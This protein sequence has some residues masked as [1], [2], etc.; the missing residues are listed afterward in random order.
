[1]DAAAVNLLTFFS[2]NEKFIIP[3][4]QR[5]YSWEARQCKELFEDIFKLQ[6]N[7]E[8]LLGMVIYQT[9]LQANGLH[10]N[11]II[12]GQQRTT[13]ISLLLKAIQTRL[14]EINQN[15]QFDH[16]ISQIQAF[17]YNY[18]NGQ[19]IKLELGNM[20]NAD[21]QSIIN[22]PNNIV[23]EHQ[24]PRINAAYQYFHQS[25]SQLQV[26]ELTRFY[27][28]LINNAIVVRIRIDTARDAYI[29]FETTNNRG[30]PL[31]HTDLI[32]NFLLGKI[33]EIA[34]LQ[35]DE[36]ILNDAITTW[37][38]IIRNI[39]NLPS[40]DEFLRHFL[41]SKRKT[42]ISKSKIS[43]DFKSY[44]E[45]ENIH[46]V[47]GQFQFAHQQVL[48]NLNRF[49][50]IYKQ[51]H[52]STFTGNRGFLNPICDNLKA[53]KSTPSYSFMM[54]LFDAEYNLDNQT[55][56]S[57]SKIIETFMLRLHICSVQTGGTD[58]IFA[59]LINCFEHANNTQIF[60]NDI[61]T[62]LNRHTPTDAR[63][64]DSLKN[65]D[66]SASLIGRARYILINLF[67]HGQGNFQALQI[68]G[69]NA[70]H[71][72]HILPLRPDQNF[73]WENQLGANYN[74]LYPNHIHKIGNLTLLEAPLNILISNSEYNRKRPF[75][76]SS[77]ILQTSQ[78]A[79][80]YNN[81]NYQIVSERSNDIALTALQIWPF[82]EP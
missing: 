11:E 45:N 17:L 31:S 77:N 10:I 18:I 4:Y 64:L 23:F 37:T 41:I 81:F 63:F 56:I 39:E 7:R 62:K 44:F 66:F 61:K 14:R 78:L 16:M 35:N 54:N 8:H 19:T 76:R 71:V 42:V 49:S 46:H 29:L 68:L 22:N 55:I 58:A 69:P 15:N 5:R 70:V 34:E 65:Y 50:K 3:A 43:D 21:F 1:M 72:E 80:L 20:D 26:Q 32:K 60:I 47:V 82:I 33:A 38:Q 51:I 79:N 24:N 73:N 36:Q 57:V 53:I 52:E 48:Q 59:D 30:K 13:S 12:D 6:Q 28:D 9:K 27:Y 25:V 75:L 67:N 74:N 2:T 40:E